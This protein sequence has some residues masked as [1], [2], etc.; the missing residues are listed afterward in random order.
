[1]IPLKNLFM[2]CNKDILNK[3]S[4]LLLQKKGCSD[5]PIYK[6]MNKRDVLGVIRTKTLLK[7][8]EKYMN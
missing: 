3:D 1:M 7:I 4:L 8:G 5:V 2:I 6:N